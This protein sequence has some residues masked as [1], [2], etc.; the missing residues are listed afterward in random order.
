LAT[1]K[2]CCNQAMLAAFRAANSAGSG[3]VS[4]K[5]IARPIER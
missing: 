3:A 2:V 5:F 1:A 4:H